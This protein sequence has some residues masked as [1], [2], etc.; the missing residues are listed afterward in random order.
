MKIILA[1]IILI[2]TLTKV[3]AQA[4]PI[5]Y[6]T[7][8]ESGNYNCDGTSDQVEINQALD[9]VAENSDYTTVYLKGAYIYLRYNF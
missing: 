2:F 5:I 4:P 7:G 8:D 9:F 3:N 1:F 6:V